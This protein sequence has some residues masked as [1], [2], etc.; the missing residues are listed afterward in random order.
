MKDPW[1]LNS[2]YSHELSAKQ[3]TDTDLFT[4][5]M[6]PRNSLPS[7][8]MWLN[9]IGTSWYLSPYREKQSKKR[10]WYMVHV[11]SGTRRG[12]F[13]EVLDSVSEETR[14]KLLFNLDLFC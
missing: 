11:H 8:L 12:T 14:T 4:P 1:H 2:I 10:V 9:L 13:E 7:S 3:F 5:K 6:L